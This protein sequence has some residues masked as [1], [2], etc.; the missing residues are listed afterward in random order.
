MTTPIHRI[1][2]IAPSSKATMETEP[3]EPYMDEF[4]AGAWSGHDGIDMRE[5]AQLERLVRW[6]SWSELFRTL[7]DD[8]A[9]NTLAAGARYVENDWF[10]TPDVETYAAMLADERPA[11]VIEVGG[12]FST[13]V[14]RRTIAALALPTHL[15]VVDPEPRLDLAEVADEVIPSRVEAARSLPQAESMLLFIDSSH[16]TQ[17]GGDVPFL[18][19]RLI[20]SLPAGA[21]VHAHDIFIPFDY[22][23]DYHERGYTEQYVLHAL[24]AG[25]NYAVEFASVYM[26][27]R[28]PEAMSTTF[29]ETVPARHAGASLW[30]RSKHSR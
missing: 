5:T 24:L 11:L 29:G 27:W 25:G 10:H 1:G 9:I 16:V 13:L 6:R 21:L 17:T 7:R 28:H 15:V 26:S 3:P 12:G 2:L 18:Y 22:R 19:N 23:P 4:L 30:F 20:P 14:A 8:P